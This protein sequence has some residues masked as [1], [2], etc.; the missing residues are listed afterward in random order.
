MFSVHANELQWA[1]I[2]RACFHLLREIREKKLT[3]YAIWAI[4]RDGLVPAG[5]LAQWM[6]IRD[7]DVICCTTYDGAEK[8]SN[9][10]ITR[11]PIPPDRDGRNIL[12]IDGITDT[13]TTM[14]AVRKVLP[15][16][17]YASTFTRRRALASEHLVGGI[18]EH[19]DWVTFPYDRPYLE[20]TLPEA[21][22]QLPA[23]NKPR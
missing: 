3:I 9:C 22:L 6:C 20:V 2:H 8:L 7:V 18:I 12:V 1:D 10:R 14:E 15:L 19:L 21:N 13:G 5:I 17:Y 11:C 4:A 23:S 16:A